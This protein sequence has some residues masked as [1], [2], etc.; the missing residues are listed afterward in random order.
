MKLSLPLLLGTTFL[1]SGCDFST[2]TP[3]P[4]PAPPAA[5]LGI[6]PCD[7]FLKAYE[8][9]L[10]SLT[11]GAQAQAQSTIEQNR[12]NW[13]VQAAGPAGKAPLGEMCRKLT[14]PPT[15]PN[16]ATYN[17]RVKQ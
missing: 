9:C 2:T 12:K 15:C 5:D 4:T 13:A 8:A 10:P 6:A 17:A 3:T 11:G 1:L 16:A 7:D 14:L